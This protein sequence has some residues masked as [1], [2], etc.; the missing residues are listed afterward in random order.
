MRWLLWWAKNDPEKKCREQ[1]LQHPFHPANRPLLINSPQTAY[2]YCTALVIATNPDLREDFKIGTHEKILFVPVPS[3]S[4]TRANWQTVRWSGREI[5]QRLEKAGLGTLGILAV[6]QKPMI[7]KTKGGKASYQELHDNYQLLYT[8][9][10][11]YRVVY[12]DDILTH[13]AHVAALDAKLGSPEKAGCLCFGLTETPTRNAYDA[14]L[15]TITRHYS[16]MFKQTM[17]KVA[18]EFAY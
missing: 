16:T 1:W 12:L 5:G 4:A 6:N 18:E 17:V 8:V 11:G 10:K 7:Q 9:P 2:D 3:S 14:Q 13:G 15:R